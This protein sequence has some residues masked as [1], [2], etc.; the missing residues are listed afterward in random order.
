MAN[1]IKAKALAEKIGLPIIP[2]SSKNVETLKE[3]KISEKNWLSNNNK[4][5]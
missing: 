1:K 5:N 2:G 3:A 4:I